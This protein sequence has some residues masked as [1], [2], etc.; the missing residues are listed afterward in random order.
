MKKPEK[1]DKL[2]AEIESLKSLHNKI[3]YYHDK[4]KYPL[5]SLMIDDEFC[6]EV[7]KLFKKQL[8]KIMEEEISIVNNKIDELY[9]QISEL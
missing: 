6:R 8:V 3:D 4:L 2:F 1:Y 7:V 5:L 9:N